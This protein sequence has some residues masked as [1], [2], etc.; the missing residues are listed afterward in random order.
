MTVSRTRPLFL[1][2]GTPVTFV[3][4]TSRGRFQVKLPDNHP[5]AAGQ[6][7]GRIFDPT[8]GA[9]YKRNTNLTLTN[10]APVAAATSAAVNPSLPMFLNDGTPVTLSKVTRRGRIQVKLPANHPAAAGQENGWLFEAATGAR[11]K[12]RTPA[13]TLTNTAPVSSDDASYA[14]A[15][16]GSIINDGFASFDAAETA[17]LGSLNTET[18]S[19]TILK[20]STSVAGVVGIS[21]TRA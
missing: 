14:L 1:S 16:N 4:T 18:R 3:K 19:V 5:F 20:V 13:I 17:A 6:D 11:Y 21:T 8:T 7:N 9:H 10:T 15:V 12:G 2:D